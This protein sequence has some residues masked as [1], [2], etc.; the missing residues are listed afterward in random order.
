M[1]PVPFRPSPEHETRVQAELARREAV[2]RMLTDRTLTRTDVLHVALDL[3]L[4]VL[5]GEDLASALSTEH[6]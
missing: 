3:G 6:G 1:R 2:P 5:E 4:A